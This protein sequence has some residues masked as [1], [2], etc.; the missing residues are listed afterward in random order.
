MKKIINKTRMMAFIVT[1]LSTVPLF[2][3]YLTDSQPKNELVIHLHV[4]F[5]FIFIVISVSS[6][7]L[8]KRKKL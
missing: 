7:V 6:M 3:S 1:I 8:E 2:L 5:G 4:W